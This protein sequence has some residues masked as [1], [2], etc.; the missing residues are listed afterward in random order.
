MKFIASVIAA[1]FVF[2]SSY[3][4]FATPAPPVQQNTIELDFS[5]TF[6]SKVLEKDATVKQVLLCPRVT[7]QPK[8]DGVLDDAS[9][10]KAFAI[11]AFKPN[12]PATRAQ[13][14]YDADNLYIAIVCSQTSNAPTR[15]T[16]CPHNTGTPWK[17]D[18]VEVFV[19]AEEGTQSTKSQFIVNA[20]GST[21]DV[22]KETSS[23]D[24]PRWSDR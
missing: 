17:D 24:V 22:L 13:I 1:L 21:F 12:N 6:V 23:G 16:K 9:W 8:V 3:L 10:K 18:C 15:A 20:A 4:A 5:P 19:T 11:N 14:S 7:E 2:D